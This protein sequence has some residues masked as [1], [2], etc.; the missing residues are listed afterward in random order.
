[1]LKKLFII[2]LFF[3]GLA[4]QGCDSVV[5][6]NS[7]TEV[8]NISPAEIKKETR[9]PQK[10]EVPNQQKVEFKGVSFSYNQQIFGEVKIE[11]VAELPLENEDDKPENVAPQHRLFTFAERNQRNATIAVYPIAE[12]RRVWLPV[13]KNNT[14]I[15]DEDLNSLKELIKN[16][17]L[18]REGEI[19]FLTYYDAHQTFQ[20]K[21]KNFSFQNG[22]GIFFLTQINQD[23][24][25]INN[26][27]I[28]YFFQGISEDGKNY[29]LAEFPVS[30]SFLPKDQYV[31]NFEGYSISENDPTGKKYKEYVAK[32]TKRLE[33]LPS[34]KY[35]PNLKYFE[36][37]ISSLRIEK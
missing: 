26:N 18:R 11:E 37:I 20:A 22:K 25:F 2:G 6:Q 14:K 4:L 31:E 7:E 24:L 19:P 10:D 27:Q 23:Y 15:F 21:A 30:V 13:E 5:S 8:V 9:Q 12:F 1:M 3:T 35:E 16:P 34:D 36:E 29:I 28:A 32:I 17:K 33:N